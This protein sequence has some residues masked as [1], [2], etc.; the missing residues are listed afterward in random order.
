MSKKDIYVVICD[1]DGTKYKDPGGPL[2]LET[3]IKFS[4]LEHA[5]ERANIMSKRHGLCRIAK[6]EILENQDDK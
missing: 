3:Y 1:N 6:V 5:K 4:S 2:V